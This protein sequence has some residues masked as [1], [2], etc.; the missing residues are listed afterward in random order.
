MTSSDFESYRS[1][2]FRYVR[3]VV[4]GKVP[5]YMVEDAVSETW[6][7][8]WE[9]REN[10]KPEYT[11]RPWLRNVARSAATHYRDKMCNRAYLSLPRNSRTASQMYRI[12]RIIDAKRLLQTIHPV[13]IISA[14][15]GVEGVR[16][17][18]YS[19]EQVYYE[20]R[21]LQRRFGRHGEGAGVEK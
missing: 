1:Q 15:Y 19:S 9:R 20:R 12:E 10:Y 6:L 16:A 7:K 8:V 11:L 4:M 18:G 17:A 14:E 21:K 13:L 5:D 2:Y 3:R